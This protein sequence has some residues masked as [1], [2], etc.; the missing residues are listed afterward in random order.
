MSEQVDEPSE[1]RWMLAS[2]CRLAL[3]LAVSYVLSAA[4][5]GGWSL[6]AGMRMSAPRQ[7]GSFCSR[8]SFTP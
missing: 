2:T 4:V 8:V 7:S 3:V 5:F 6:L 1:L